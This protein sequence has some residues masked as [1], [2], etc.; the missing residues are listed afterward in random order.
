MTVTK[1]Q[2]QEIL[3]A[4]NFDAKYDSKGKSFYKDYSFGVYNVRLTMTYKYGF[5]ECFYTLSG[6]EERITGRFN[7]IATMQDEDFRTKV[8]HNFPIATSV[9]DLENILNGIMH[10]HNEFITQLAMKAA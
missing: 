5:I 9:A 4:G 10:L 1:D 8:N 7:S 3:V 2:M 6:N